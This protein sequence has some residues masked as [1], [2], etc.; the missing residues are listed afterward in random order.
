MKGKASKVAPKSIFYG[1]IIDRS[2]A[3]VIF[4]QS[5]YIH[6]AIGKPLRRESLQKKSV[7]QMSSGG[8]L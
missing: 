4:V 7:F 3:G 2:L 6:M 5:T 1:G 8:V